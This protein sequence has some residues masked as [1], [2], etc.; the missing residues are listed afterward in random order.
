MTF[1]AFED[2]LTDAE[3]PAGLSPYLGALW[4]ERLG[5]WDKAH[6]IV[7]DIETAEASAIHAYLHRKE[8]DESNARYW[9]GQAGKTFPAGK[10]LDDEW[11][12]L[13]NE[14]L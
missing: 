12:S 13:V 2:G 7:Q 8:G 1:D 4:Y 3:P 6:K 9:Y 11:K 10:T 14:L 5:D